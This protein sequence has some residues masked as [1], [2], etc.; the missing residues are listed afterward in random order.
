MKNKPILKNIKSHW[1]SRL[2]ALPL[3]INYPGHVTTTI[4]IA[5]FSLLFTR[6]SLNSNLKEEENYKFLVQWLFPLP[7]MHIQKYFFA[8]ILS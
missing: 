1:L 7:Q 2:A 6:I 3:V 8:K 4:I 5:P